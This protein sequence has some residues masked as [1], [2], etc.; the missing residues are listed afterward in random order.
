MGFWGMSTLSTPST[1]I[2]DDPTDKSENSYDQVYNND[3][4]EENKSSFG[5]EMIAGGAAFAGFKAFEDHQRKEGMYLHRKLSELPLT[6]A[7]ASPSL[8][9]SPRSSLLALLPPKSTRYVAHHA[10]AESY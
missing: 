4:F 10:C 1:D 8:T 3:N 2:T 5:H 9:L 6:L 7:Q